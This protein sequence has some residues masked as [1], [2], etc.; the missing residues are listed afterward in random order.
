MNLSCRVVLVAG[1]VPP[2]HCS[3]SQTLPTRNVA[4]SQPLRPPFSKVQSSTRCLSATTPALRIVLGT[5]AIPSWR[6]WDLR[7]RVGAGDAWTSATQRSRPNVLL[8]GTRWLSVGRQ[9]IGSGSLVYLTRQRL[10][11]RAIPLINDRRLEETRLRC[12]STPRPALRQVASGSVDSEVEWESL[13]CRI[14]NYSLAP[15]GREAA[16]HERERFGIRP[17]VL[18][19][20]EP[21]RPRSVAL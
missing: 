5:K 16:S 3:S 15:I 12:C 9:L 18:V 20:R 4:G 17:R 7:V 14:A 6:Q 13:P 19:V 10:E 1:A 11:L 8:G 2:F 21:G